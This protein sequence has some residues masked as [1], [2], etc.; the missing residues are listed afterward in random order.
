MRKISLMLVTLFCTLFAAQ[1]QT[2]VT[3]LAQLSN[4]KVYTLRSERA[5]LLYSTA[6]PGSICSSNGSS[7]GSVEFSNTDENLQF[8]IEKVGD[9]YYLFSEGAQKYVSSNGSYV[10]KASAAVL[11]LNG[12]DG[13]YSWQ[14]GRAHV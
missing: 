2:L 1:A 3:D 9:N 7:V 8:R 4:D 6:V 13:D 10:E 5:F 12:V 11:T 14:I